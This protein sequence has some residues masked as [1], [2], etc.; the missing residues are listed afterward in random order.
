M[1]EKMLEL[2]SAYLDG[3][4]TP[5]ERKQVEAILQGS[6]QAREEFENMRAFM[7]MINESKP[8]EV[9]VPPEFRQNIMQRLHTHTGGSGKGSGSAGFGNLFLKQTSSWILVGTV[10]TGLI[11]FMVYLDQTNHP[12]NVTVNSGSHRESL[13][14]TVST[15]PEK[16]FPEIS[17]TDK[18]HYQGNQN[19]Q[20][21]AIDDIESVVNKSSAV[22]SP[23]EFS[24]TGTVYVS[25]SGRA[26]K[27]GS[28]SIPEF[29]EQTKEMDI[30][31]HTT[32]VE[33]TLGLESSTGWSQPRIVHVYQMMNKD[34][35]ITPK[36]VLLLAQHYNLS[37]GL[38]VAASLYTK[39]DEIDI[40]AEQMRTALNHS[41]GQTDEERL[42]GI[43]SCLNGDIY[44]LEEWKS[45]LLNQK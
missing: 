37:P 39:S 41:V 10:L 17:E 20:D 30:A 24:L 6:T 11:G 26:E 13:S 33:S 18:T 44:W 43:I 23:G 19:T 35:K 14:K 32:V 40:I 38:I 12:A 3:R 36:R 25:G 22:V 27:K 16:F 9:K 45:I 7:E 1:N 2:F 5:A 28:L 4:G 8:P 15:K 34:V 21:I 31:D 29:E 42:R